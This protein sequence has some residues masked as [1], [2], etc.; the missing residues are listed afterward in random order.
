[1]LNCKAYNLAEALIITWAEELCAHLKSIVASEDERCGTQ[2][3]CQKQHE[4]FEAASDPA[5]TS[6]DYPDPSTS[7][8]DHIDGDSSAAAGKSSQPEPPDALGTTYPS[9]AMDPLNDVSSEYQQMLHLLN[10]IQQADHC[11]VFSYPITDDIAPEYSSI[12]TRPM[13]ISTIR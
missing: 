2:L 13:D 9:T 10:L 3:C 8:S 7:C 5:A 4:E 12:I 11:E 1:M 6:T